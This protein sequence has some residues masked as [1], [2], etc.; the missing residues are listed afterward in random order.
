MIPR[1][2]RRIVLGP[3]HVVSVVQLPHAKY[4]EVADEDDEPRQNRSAAHADLGERVIYLDCSLPLSRRWRAFRH[5]LMHMLID[6]A[7]MEMGGV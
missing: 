7:L 4:A 2:P 6:I 5:E 3:E 1:L